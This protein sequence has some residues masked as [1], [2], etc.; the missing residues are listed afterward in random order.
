MKHRTQLATW[1][2]RVNK[3]AH[4]LYRIR[5]PNAVFRLFVVFSC[6]F[7]CCDICLVEGRLFGLLF[8]IT[9]SRLGRRTRSW[10]AIQF[11]FNDNSFWIMLQLSAC[12]G[13][14][15]VS[16]S[17]AIES[18]EL[19]ARLVLPVALTFAFVSPMYSIRK[20]EIC[21][22]VGNYCNKL[23]WTF[24]VGASFHNLEFTQA[25]SINSFA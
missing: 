16:L 13:E 23:H 14:Y 6:L 4:D 3:S 19:W 20:M 12:G 17:A 24:W 10:H 25:R 15:P 22:C 8:R 18:P 21:S 11:S 5:S 9:K 7:H 1:L 2:F